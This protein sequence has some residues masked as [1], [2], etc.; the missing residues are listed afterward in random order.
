MDIPA[1]RK[2]QLLGLLHA[3]T[4]SLSLDGVQRKFENRFTYIHD[5]L[6][7]DIADNTR[8][9]E[10][11][12]A[13]REG[14]KKPE[15]IAFIQQK[16]P[17]VAHLAQNNTPSSHFLALGSDILN[18]LSNITKNIVQT[19]IPK[20]IAVAPTPDTV[21]VPGTQNTFS[22]KAPNTTGLSRTR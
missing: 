11:I 6:A 5:A 12:A 16:L 8:I 1:P 18:P 7:K 15:E 13:W 2:N 4:P 3:E 9:I 21:Y 14:K 10:D 20:T 19:E 22:D 17:N